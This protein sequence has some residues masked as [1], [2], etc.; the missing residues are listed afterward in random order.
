MLLKIHQGLPE[1]FTKNDLHVCFAQIEE[2]DEALADQHLLDKT[3]MARANRFALKA[4]KN[5][6]ISTH[7][8]YEN[9]LV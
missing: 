8:F 5:S 1:Y 7:V 9:V 4:L 2:T 3:E 6:F